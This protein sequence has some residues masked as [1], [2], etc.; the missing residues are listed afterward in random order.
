[1]LTVSVVHRLHSPYLPYERILKL[2][3]SELIS[4]MFSRAVTLTRYLPGFNIRSPN[5]LSKEESP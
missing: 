2:V 4:G 5:L 1:M 3:L